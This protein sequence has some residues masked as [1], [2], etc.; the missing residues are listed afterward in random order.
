M[1]ITPC[2][3]D[4]RT[5]NRRWRYLLSLNLEVFAVLMSFL[6]KLA[7]LI[8]VILLVF[9]TVEL[10]GLRENFSKAFI[11]Q[12][13]EDNIVLGSMMFILMFVIANFI[14]L[15]GIIF[16]TAAIVVLGAVKAA[17]LI[18]FATIFSCL[19]SYFVIG[20]LGGDAIR[21]LEGK[22]VQFWLN[23]VDSQP[24][25]SVLILR[26]LFGTTP[27]LNY[28]LCLTGVNFKHYMVGS[29]IGLIFPAIVHTFL[30][31]WVV[32]NINAL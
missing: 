32:S 20:F 11:E 3:M 10:L 21:A 9:L 8:A 6:K 26:S 23:K 5:Y 14:Q 2:H 31:Q 18:Y 4:F 16:L 27:A 15:P 22:Y 25:K 19:F 1:A 12:T 30:L 24:F 28:A 7:P 13:I 29:C 17:I